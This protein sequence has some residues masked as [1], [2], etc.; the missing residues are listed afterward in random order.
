MAK[1]QPGDS[2]VGT[3]GA[4]NYPLRGGKI[5]VMEGGIRLN[6][7]A[8]GGIIPP[9]L[10]GT[11]H[12]GWWHLSDFYAT[13]SALAGVDPHDAR[14]EAAGLPPID[15]LDMSGVLLGVNATSPRT[16]IIIGSSDTSDHEGG[17]IVAGVIDSSGWK[18]LIGNVDPAFFQGPVYPNASTSTTPP[19]H[20]VCGDPQGSGASRGPGC[21]FNVLTDPNE[22]MDL[23]ATNPGKVKELRDRITAL[24]AT[25]YSPD[26]G[27]TDRE[28]CLTGRS[29][30]GGFL[31]PWLP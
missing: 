6:A 9:S 26:R 1:S 30:W 12:T 7:F 20:L 27:G 8:S 2:L 18:L 4:N 24:Q 23:A 11:V 16:E 5:G 17:T 21:L 29:K 14:G 3:S 10:R 19:P 13:F 25:V 15:S 22:T 31:G 28:M